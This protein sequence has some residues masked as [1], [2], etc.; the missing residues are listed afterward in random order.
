MVHHQALCKDTST[1]AMRTRPAE[2]TQSDTTAYGLS[3]ATSLLAAYRLKV[4]SLLGMMGVA[5][6][7]VKTMGAE[8]WFQ[9]DIIICCLHNAAD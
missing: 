8:A 6:G 9:H 1:V 4:D 7:C 3:T 2:P 5:D